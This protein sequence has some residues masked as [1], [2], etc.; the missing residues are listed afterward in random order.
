MSSRLLVPGTQLSRDGR[1][2][3]AA[4]HAKALRRAQYEIETH[5]GKRFDSHFEYLGVKKHSLGYRWDPTHRY[6]MGVLIL[7]SSV[8]SLPASD[9]YALI[10][11]PE[12]TFYMDPELDTNGTGSIGDPFQYLQVLGPSPS[13]SITSIAG[14]LECVIE[15]LPGDRTYTDTGRTGSE[16][17]LGYWRPRYD[18]SETHP[19]IIRAQ[20]PCTRGGSN[21]TRILQ[22][23][24]AYGACQLGIGESGLGSREWVFLSG[25]ELP[26]W[27]G[28]DGY[29]TGQIGLW[30]T[31]NCKVVRC[32]C[33]AE[34]QGSAIE[35]TNGGSCFA[36]V[37]RFLEVG[38][39]IF[40]NY[41][42]G[43]GAGGAVF[44]GFESYTLQDSEI[45]HITVLNSYGQGVFQK[46]LDS[47]LLA[48]VPNVRNHFH[49]LFVKDVGGSGLFDFISGPNTALE[50][51]NKWTQFIV[52]G[53]GRGGIELSHGYTT[54]AADH[55]GSIFQNG[56]VAN[57]QSGF[58]PVMSSD[59]AYK[60][61]T[62]VYNVIFYS[63]TNQAINMND[64]F[65]DN[66][67]TFD[68]EFLLD[69]NQYHGNGLIFEDADGTRTF[70]QM[71]T[72]VGDGG[73]DVEEHGNTGDPSFTNPATDDYTLQV[74]SSARSAGLD[75]LS[76]AGGG[77]VHRGAYPSSMTDVIGCRTTV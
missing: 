19:V 58:A 11:D 39:C 60:T 70:A 15:S 69:Y 50:D 73:Q 25:F 49:H 26:T 6:L 56:V 27:N 71:Q 34:G 62:R 51:S 12:P 35:S 17:K 57:C 40:R 42:D 48:T 65:F 63:N 53:T 66:G 38:D 13:S 28:S 29:E 74:G 24:G 72:L 23:P 75:F 59:F 76:I 10:D 52:K 9:T 8:S 31:D 3:A 7:R 33:D 55:S 20:E 1:L 77:T 16:T 41:G 14:T 37:N 67:T 43:T 64:G 45:H 32:I 21:K 30:G 54:E 61:P 36:Q 18:G 4:K 44:S 47:G 68:N 5:G 22:T 46:G 2:F